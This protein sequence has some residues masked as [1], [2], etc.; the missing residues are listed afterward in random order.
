[1]TFRL[2]FSAFQD[3]E[4]DAQSLEGLLNERGQDGG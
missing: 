2:I 4:K 1:M 3:M